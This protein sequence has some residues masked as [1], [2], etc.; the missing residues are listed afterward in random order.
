MAMEHI[1]GNL[2]KIEQNMRINSADPIALQ[3]FTQLPNFILRN[4]ICPPA[5]A[6]AIE[7]GWPRPQGSVRSTRA[8]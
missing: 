2:Q 1:G 6:A 7:A 3:G 5:D 8:R 4:R